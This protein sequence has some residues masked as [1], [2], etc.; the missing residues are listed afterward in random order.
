MSEISR[1]EI[2]E[3]A[4]MDEPHVS[5]L[6]DELTTLRTRLAD[7]EREGE[8]LKEELATLREEL[9]RVKGEASRGFNEWF[10]KEYEG[11]KP[12]EAAP[13]SE[14]ELEEAFIAGCATARAEG[15]RNGLEMAAKVVRGTRL[16][17]AG[18]FRLERTAIKGKDVEFMLDTIESA[19]RALTV[20]E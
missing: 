13:F 18:G 16:G 11:A 19:I 20:G 1:Q 12:V 2:M 15:E 6:L 7:G 9:E 3:L 5:E 14:T 10:H 8:R 17:L 4:G